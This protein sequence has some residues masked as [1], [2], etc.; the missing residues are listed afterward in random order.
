VNPEAR[1]RPSAALVG[2]LLPEIVWYM[3]VLDRI[4]SGKAII[5]GR[6]EQALPGLNSPKGSLS[7]VACGIAAAVAADSCRAEVSWWRNLQL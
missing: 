4:H 7:H 1:P 2:V 6:L 5:V 3:A